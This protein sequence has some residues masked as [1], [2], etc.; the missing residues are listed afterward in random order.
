MQMNFEN[1]KLVITEILNHDDRYVLGSY[2]SYLDVYKYAGQGC[3]WIVK[4]IPILLSRAIR[5]KW[6][7]AIKTEGK[8]IIIGDESIVGVKQL[9]NEYKFTSKELELLRWHNDFIVIKGSYNHAGFHLDNVES[10]TIR[11]VIGIDELD[12]LDKV[13]EIVITADRSKGHVKWNVV[14]TAKNPHLLEGFVDDIQK[15]LKYQTFQEGVKEQINH[16]FANAAHDQARN[17]QGTSL[18]VVKSLEAL[19]DLLL[20]KC[21]HHNGFYDRNT[22]ENF[23]KLRNGEKTIVN[24]IGNRFNFV[25]LDFI[26][27]ALKD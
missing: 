10:I 24:L 19:S 17:I 27:L 3:T 26:E 11:P 7:I 20:S 18:Y 8:T 5:K 21:F 23:N 22:I 4:P 12:K 14:A 13:P 2:D 9:V 25:E 1:G 6:S 15:S 16:L